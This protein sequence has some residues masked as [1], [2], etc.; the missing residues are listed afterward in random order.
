M[1]L[2][3]IDIGT[4]S[5]KGLLICDTGE[6]ISRYSVSHNVNSPQSGWA[7]QDGDVVWWMETKEVIHH[8]M[9]H[10]Q[11][12][13]EKIAGIGVSGL[14]PAL[15]LADVNGKPLRPALL[16]SD[17]R[18]L[19]ELVQFN[20]DFG[21]K[22]TGDAIIP[23]LAWFRTFEPNNFRKAH[24][25]F[26]SHNYITFRLTGEYKLDYKVADSLGGLFDPYQ[27]KWKEDVA[28]WAGISTA[29][30]PILCSP[31]EIVGIL[32]PS[33][34]Q[35]I[36]LIP[37][38]PVIAGSGDSLLTM[39]G[40][41]VVNKGDALLSIGTTGWLA[42]CSC[43]MEAYFSNPRLTNEKAPYLLETYLLSCGSALD[44]CLEHFATGEVIRAKRLGISPY[45]L[46]DEEASKVPPGADGLLV[47]PYFLGGRDEEG[48]EPDRGAIIG[49]SLNHSPGH[50][51]KAF[52]ESFGYI[53]RAG[54]ERLEDKG[55]QVTKMVISGGGAGSL[56]WRQTISNII[57]KPL[58]YFV[59]ADPCIGSAV[60][61]GYSLGLWNSVGK[62][63]HWFPDA[64]VSR[65]VPTD[66]ALYDDPYKRFLNMYAKLLK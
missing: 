55:I 40:A 22:L 39:I 58:D 8:L 25:Y 36:G 44:W 17:N 7:E 23:K 34:A 56:A 41:G 13:P 61:V 26:S 11:A 20:L 62:V 14:F 5:T 43:N 32:T 52:I 16:Y 37:G 51:Y 53:V 54:L 63:S 24:Y 4:L 35:E 60:L 48:L 10:P 47:F 6:I 65:P 45:Q 2:I 21:S 9:A 12:Q 28:R 66:H 18:A 38:I 3:G 29:R 64:K 19:R 33:A 49:L 57:N 46:L 27:L 30:L 31:T 15:L 59:D 50:F 42:V 1:Q